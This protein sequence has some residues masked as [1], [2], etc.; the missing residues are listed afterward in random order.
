MSKVYSLALA[1]AVA[2]ASFAA[3]GSAEAKAGNGGSK[4]SFSSSKSFSSGKSFTTS[5]LIVSKHVHHDKFRY[6]GYVY[7]APL[8]YASYSS[9]GW[10]KARAL[11]T[12]SPRWWARYEACRD[13]S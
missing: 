6:R 2:L 4:G 5:K 1:A 3:A 13:E 12:G 9:C 8:V 11:E 7:A 10:L